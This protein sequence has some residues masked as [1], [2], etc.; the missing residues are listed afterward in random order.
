MAAEEFVAQGE[1]EGRGW[2]DSFTSGS[3]HLYSLPKFP[4]TSH[5]SILR[6]ITLFDSETPMLL[7]RKMLGVVSLSS[8][9]MGVW[10][11]WHWILSLKATLAE[12]FLCL[13]ARLN[14]KASCG[15]DRIKG[16]ETGK[17]KGRGRA[18]R[19]AAGDVAYMVRL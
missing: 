5:P 11:S 6:R 13:E 1:A 10:Q 15:E 16:M 12:D 8:P 19:L 14:R 17:D 9:V 18:L 4:H 3:E 7:V 2:L